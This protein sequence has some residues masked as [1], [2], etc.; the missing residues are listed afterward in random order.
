MILWHGDRAKAA[1]HEG[2]VKGLTKWAED[3]LE[4]SQPEV[5]VAAEGGGFLRDSGKV[6]VDDDA[7]VATISYSSP[8]TRSD[9]RRAPSASVAVIVHENMRAHHTTGNAKFL[10]NPANASKKSGP[11]TVRDAIKKAV[12]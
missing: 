4:V 11:Q 9:G 8:P 10:E 12:G 1:V 6:E 5:P 3:V 7:L 2:A